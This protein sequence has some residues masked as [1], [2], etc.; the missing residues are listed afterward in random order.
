MQRYR[1]FVLERIFATKN[2]SLSAY[3][4]V[5]LRICVTRSISYVGPE[6]GFHLH[7]FRVVPTAV[8]ISDNFIKHVRGRDQRRQSFLQTEPMPDRDPMILIV[9]QLER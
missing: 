7:R 9:R 5:I 4:E 1:I 2:P 6:S 3:I 8:E